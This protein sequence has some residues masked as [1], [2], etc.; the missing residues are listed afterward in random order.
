MQLT[1][2]FSRFSS[3]CALDTHHAEHNQLVNGFVKCLL[4]SCWWEQFHQKKNVFYFV[5]PSCMLLARKLSIANTS[6]FQL[7]IRPFFHENVRIWFFMLLFVV[8]EQ[9]RR[10]FDQIWCLTIAIWNK[11]S[12]TSLGCEKKYGKFSRK[13]VCFSN[14]K[15]F[16]NRL[17]EFSFSIAR[18]QSSLEISAFF[19]NSK[20]SFSSARTSGDGPRL[21]SIVSVH[22][23][24]FSLM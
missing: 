8:R 2:V 18:F 4:D 15:S 22:F 13:S 21:V 5:R 9:L 10:T 24:F 7:V 16:R 19:K 3:K 14:N 1:L 20:S 11:K 6:Q 17:L 12:L 23:F